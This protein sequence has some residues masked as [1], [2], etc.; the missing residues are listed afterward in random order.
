MK[1]VVIKRDDA[2]LPV[3]DDGYVV[4]RYDGKIGGSISDDNLEKLRGKPFMTQHSLGRGNVICLADD[5]TIRGFHHAGMR[6]LMN[7]IVLGPSQ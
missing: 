4:A 6:L 5:V 7:A 2:F 3:R 1:P